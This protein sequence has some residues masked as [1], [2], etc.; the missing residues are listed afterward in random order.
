MKFTD[1]KRNS[2]HDNPSEMVSGYLFADAEL[3]TFAE[4]LQDYDFATQA[5]IEYAVRLFLSVICSDAYIN[6]KHLDEINPQAD[7]I[8]KRFKKIVYD[9]EKSSRF[10]KKMASEVWNEG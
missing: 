4:W 10:C 8:A 3:R 5:E 9:E 7:K 2:S 6:R 1:L